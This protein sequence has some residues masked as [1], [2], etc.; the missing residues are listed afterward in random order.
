MENYVGDIGILFS[1][2]LVMV[3]VMWDK[4]FSD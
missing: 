2:V 4:L 3:Y 1:I